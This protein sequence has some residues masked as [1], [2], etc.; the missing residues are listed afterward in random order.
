MLNL[1]RVNSYL[2][3]KY[4]NGG[5]SN[6]KQTQAERV[7]NFLNPADGYWSAPY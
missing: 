5:K 7:Y 6:I 2:I 1:N 4:Q 3:Q